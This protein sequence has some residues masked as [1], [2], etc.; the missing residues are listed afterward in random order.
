MWASA[1]KGELAKLQVAQNRVARLV[2]GCSV[3]T[4]VDKMHSRLQWLKVEKRL[5]ASTVTFFNN[6]MRTKTPGFLFEQIVFCSS[7]HSYSTRNAVNGNIAQATP[8][9]NSLTRTV[10]Y[11]AS[12][13]WNNLP[14]KIRKTQNVCAFKRELRS[15]LIS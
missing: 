4:S 3:R 6:T 11:R 1:S 14:I 10:F 13:I 5:V 12:T 2:L 7:V 15:H 9:S 8:N